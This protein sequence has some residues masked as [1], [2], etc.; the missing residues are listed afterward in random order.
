MFKISMRCLFLVGLFAFGPLEAI[1]LGKSDVFIPSKLGN[2]KLFHNQDG[3]YVEKDGDICSVQN[4][5]VDKAIRNISTKQLMLF[6]GKTK[7]VELHG[8]KI[9]FEKISKKQFNKLCEKTESYE[10]IDLDKPEKEVLYSQLNS[11]SAY[12]VVNQLADGEY[13][14]ASK[15]RLLGGGPISGIIGYWLT[16]TVCYGTATAAAASIVVAT[17]GAA[18]A[19]AGAAAAGITAG[20]STGAAVVGGAIAGAGFAAEAAVVTG[21]A[22]GAVGTVSGVIVAVEST[23]TAVGVFLTALPFLP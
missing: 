10:K 22:V 12:I 14:L 7:I 17:G 5:F 20:A 6:L 15:H 8:Q 19:A 4:C 9:V 21:T 11:S 3:F 2:V 23:S 13:I 1:Q 16:K 18:G